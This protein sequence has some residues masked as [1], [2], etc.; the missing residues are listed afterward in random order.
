MYPES[1]NG[2]IC[3]FLTL[4]DVIKGMGGDLEIVARIPDGFVRINQFESLDR[5]LQI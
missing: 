3:T 4:R 2:P 1:K 5:P